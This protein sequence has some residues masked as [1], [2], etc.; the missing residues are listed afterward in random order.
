MY[1]AMNDGCETTADTKARYGDGAVKKFFAILGAAIVLGQVYNIATPLGVRAPKPADPP[2]AAPQR[3]GVNS[4]ST[5]APAATNSA[6]ALRWVEVEPLLTAGQVVLLDARAKAAY[7]IEHIPGAISLPAESQP[8]EFIAFAA[9]Y[10]QNTAIVVYCGGGNCDLSH[11]LRE[12]L[13][14][15]L[16]YTNVREMPGGIVEWRVAEGKATP[17]DAK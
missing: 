12:K 15:D 13:R 11:E 10:P 9:K 3:P 5:N 14:K 16:G 6:F 4:A 8:A 7:D 17:P 1:A 2:A